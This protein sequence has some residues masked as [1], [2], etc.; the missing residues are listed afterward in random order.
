VSEGAGTTAWNAT[1]LTEDTTYYWRAKASDGPSESPWVQGRFSVN[2]V[3]SAPGPVSLLNPADGA[4]DNQ[5]SAVLQ[6][7]KHADGDG[8]PLSYQYEVYADAAP[9]NLVAS[10]A[11]PDALLQVTPALPDY[12]WY[13]WRVR[14]NDGTQTGPWSAG[15]ALYIHRR[16]ITEVGDANGDGRVDSLDLGRM[17]S[18]WAHAG[19][20]DLD[21]NGVAGNKDL[22]QLLKQW[23]RP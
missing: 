7:V 9:T 20:M 16:G 1:G 21:A 5:L 4:W 19:R 12:N 3:N 10:G 11:S 15:Q 23:S 6:L 8:D 22:T 13:W 2:A 14:G 18:Q 17:M